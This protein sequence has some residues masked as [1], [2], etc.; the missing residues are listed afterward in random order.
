MR[1]F[2]S[3]PVGWRNESYR[4]YLAAKGVRTKNDMIKGGLADRYGS[5]RYDAGQIR[6]GIKVEMEHTDDPRIAEEIARDH[7]EED[8]KYYDH[9]EEMEKKYMAQKYYA[10]AP[11]YVTGDLPLIAGDALGTVGAEA[12]SWI[13]VAVPLAMLYGGTKYVKG[14]YDKEKKK[15]KKRSMAEKGDMVEMTPAD[16]R[17]FDAEMAAARA[18]GD[19]QF[20]FKGRPVLVSYGKYVS[21]YLHKEFG[22]RKFALKERDSDFVEIGGKTYF[23]AEGG[24]LVNIHDASDMLQDDDEAILRAQQEAS[25]LAY[26]GVVP[27]EARDAVMSAAAY[28]V[29]AYAKKK[30]FDP[31]KGTVQDILRKRQRLRVLGIVKEK[32]GVV[33]SAQG[34]RIKARKLVAGRVYPVSPEEVKAIVG[35]AKKGDVKGIR[36]IEFVN[37][38]GG[39]KEA[40]GQYL[41]GKKKILIFSQPSEGGQIDGMPA[42]QVRS[43]IK[44]Y[45]VPHEI[46]HHKALRSGKTDRSL[47]LAEARADANVIGMSPFD[48]DVKALVR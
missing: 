22:R 12:V 2:R 37:P 45:V 20:S 5:S 23:K 36:S 9:L 1:S 8:P 18:R 35:R 28:P 26:A 41:R 6:K 48:R 30:R 3:K 13:P 11:T 43:H 39:Q 29:P 14:Q 24:T 16:L 21:E 33:G 40:W 27:W 10:Y 32:P 31:Q 42:E 47:A 7:L 38:R 17:A 4:H 44:R 46:G 19:D 25:S 34:V 15:G